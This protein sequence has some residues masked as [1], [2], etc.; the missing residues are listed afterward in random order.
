MT[1]VYLV[2]HGESTWNDRRRLQGQADPPLSVEGRH[3]SRALARALNG[4]V[5]DRVVASDLVRTRQTVDL[6]GHDQPVLAPSWREIDVGD[7]QGRPIAE[8]VAANGEAY[9]GWRHG[10]HTP[11]GG[12]PWPDFCRR[13]GT[14]LAALVEGG[15]PRALVVTHG[16][17]IRAV[18]QSVIG[19]D[20][21]HLEAVAPARATILAMAPRPRLVAYNVGIA[22]SGAVN[23]QAL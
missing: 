20:P 11:P 15:Y 5:F 13:I 18:L 17:V 4:I 8:L 21:A 6:L 1:V 16:G 22:I 14:A 7:W 3:Q 9:A 10:T 12:E 23:D 2:R 19:L